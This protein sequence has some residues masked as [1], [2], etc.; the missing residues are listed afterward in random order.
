MIVAP[1]HLRQPV[2]GGA[3]PTVVNC[4]ALFDKFFPACGLLDY[5]EGIYHGD[6]STPLETAQLDQIRYVLDEVQC[7]AGRRILDVGCGNG[8]LL[9]EVWRRGA[10]GVGITISPEQVA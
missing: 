3:E 9:E 10:I 1:P 6:P 7:T 2:N 5:T 8:A 4:Y